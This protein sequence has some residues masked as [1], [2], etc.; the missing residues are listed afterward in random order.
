M[1]VVVI[2]SGGREHAICWKILQS[3]GL[4]KIWCLPGNAG[5][6]SI[7][8]C[9]NIKS[10]DI[11]G[12]C[13]FAK[14]NNPDVVIVGPEKPLCLGISDRLSS[15]G[16]NVFGPSRIASQL[17]GSKIFA[18]LLMKKYNIP[19]AYA[20]IF[21]N[22][23]KAVAYIEKIK[24]PV[25]IKADGLAAGKGVVVAETKEEAKKAIKASMVDC[26]FG[27]SGE[28]IIIEECL[29]GEEASI[30]AFICGETIIPLAS[31][32]DHKRIGEDDTGPNTGGM[33]AYSPTPKVTESIMK[34]VEEKILKRT[35]YA[36][37]SEG[38]VFRGVLYAGIM[39]TQE[40]PKVLEFNVRFGD[41][42]TQSI[43]PRLNSDILDIMLSISQ[44]KPCITTLEWK[45]ESA[46][47][48]VLASRGYPGDY[49]KGKAIQGLDE[50]SKIKNICIFHS[51]TKFNNGRIVTDGGRVL[52]VV[53]TG[54]DI[55]DAVNRVYRAVSM[56]RF[57][58][59][60]YRK[61]IAKKAL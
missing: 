29:Y 24:I 58:N 40:G 6:A 25:V 9:V 41:P 60:Y 55:K 44:G 7:A 10:D 37:K 4:R 45:K 51:G 15:L 26:L 38:I 54:A 32:Q 19:T 14:N 39:L 22:Y 11:D 5:I 52:S 28:K 34:E 53:A 61:D 17:E 47:C 23:Q 3:L 56:I 48:V 46:V 27:S 50:V 20:E 13:Q 43:I 18:K 2:G 12:I 1:K 8:E 42:E 21:N 49:E 33:G 57:E 30:I 35:V 36:M 59:M 31:S 16:I